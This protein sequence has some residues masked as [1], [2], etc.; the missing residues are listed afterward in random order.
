MRSKLLHFNCL[1]ATLPIGVSASSYALQQN[2][3]HIVFTTASIAIVYP[4]CSRLPAHGHI[5]SLSS[6]VYSLPFTTEILRLHEVWMAR[7]LLYAWQSVTPR[8]VISFVPGQRN[9]WLSGGWARCA[10]VRCQ[11]CARSD[12]TAEESSECVVPYGDFYV[13]SV[14]YGTLPTVLSTNGM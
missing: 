10:P 13:I 9:E 11:K 5:I 2:F 7:A 12:P 14:V 1:S 4:N 6:I 8:S 3:V